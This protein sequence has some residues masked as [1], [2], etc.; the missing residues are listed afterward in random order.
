MGPGSLSQMNASLRCRVRSVMELAEE[1]KEMELA[2]LV[3]HNGMEFHNHD[4]IQLS[5][6]RLCGKTRMCHVSRRSAFH[7]AR[8]DWLRS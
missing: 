1:A 6:I 3:L 2:L 5:R 8:S 4:P 7:E